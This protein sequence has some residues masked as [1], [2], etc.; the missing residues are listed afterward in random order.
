MGC[1]GIAERPTNDGY[2]G[3]VSYPDLEITG[4]CN[5]TN[6]KAQSGYIYLNT[7]YRSK[8]DAEID[9]VVLHEPGH[10]L[11]MA[12]TECSVESVMKPG[13]CGNSHIILKSHDKL[14]INSWY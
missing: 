7:N 3:C 2:I 9:N 10:V 13:N 5:T 12:H 1:P 14:H 11:G 6:L 4:E 8:L